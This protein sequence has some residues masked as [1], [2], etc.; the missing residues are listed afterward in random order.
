MEAPPQ[1]A[2]A[3]S[4]AHFYQQQAE[5]PVGIL[6][7]SWGSS[8]L[9]AWMPRALTEVSPH[10]KIM[11]DEFDADTETRERIKSILQ[12]NP[13]SKQDDI[14]LRRQ[15]N[16]LYN[17]MIHPLIPYACQ[18]VVWYQGERN[19]QSMAGMAKSPWYSRHSG[20]LKYGET[21][22]HWMRSYRGRWED[23][24]LDFLVVMLPGYYKP[25]PTGPRNGPDHP[26][27]HSWAWMRESQ[28]KALELPHTAVANTIDLGDVKNIHPKDKLPIGKRL[29]LL[30]AEDVLEKKLIS[31]G[32]G[33]KSVA[34]K[35]EAL[36]VSFENAKGLK[37]LVGKAPT[38]FWVTDDSKEWV[39][40]KAELRGETV[41]LRSEKVAKPRYVRYA[42]VGKPQVNLV[43]GAGLPAYPFRTD[44][45]AP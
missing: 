21:L 41:V 5:V 33:V 22:Q 9:E 10:F 11:M 2:V 7:A 20:I 12:K 30:A 31:R 6:S 28:M 4:F 23:E 15:T 36:V 45:F 37:T 16:I 43:N 8:S 40:A 34:M 14:F 24:E 1:S 18:G 44:E 3:F 25:L 13:W 17:A 32:P 35:G 38:G 26:A 39:Q 27:V 42:F 29:A 19:T